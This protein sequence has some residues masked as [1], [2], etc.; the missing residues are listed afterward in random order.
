MLEYHLRCQ[1]VTVLKECVRLAGASPN[2]RG[3]K[4]DLIDALLQVCRTASVHER[5]WDFLLTHVAKSEIKVMIARRPPPGLRSTWGSNKASLIATV[6]RAD[7]P[8]AAQ[9]QDD[10]PGSSASSQVPVCGV[11]VPADCSPEVLK[12]RLRQTWIKNARR[13]LKHSAKHGNDPYLHGRL[14][15]LSSRQIQQRQWKRCD[16]R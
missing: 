1:I 11:L 3:R 10:T 4:D 13:Q 6:I 16:A 9:A 12:E 5:L 14:C 8:G 2:P 15:K 7:R